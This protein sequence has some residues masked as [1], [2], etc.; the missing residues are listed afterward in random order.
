MVVTAVVY[1]AVSIWLETVNAQDRVFTDERGQVSFSNDGFSRAL[2]TAPAIMRV[3]SDEPF[4]LEASGQVFDSRWE[5]GKV[6]SA[7]PV[8][9]ESPLDY[10]YG[11]GEK[12]YFFEREGS[13][14]LTVIVKGTFDWISTV[15]I[16]WLILGGTAGIFVVLGI[17]LSD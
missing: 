7:G 5:G 11:G 12:A 10:R 15:S 9:I 13:G 16:L 2:L 14:P 8:L 3:N 17:S 1:L 6:F 4:S